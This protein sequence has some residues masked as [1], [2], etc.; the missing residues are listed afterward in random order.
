[1]VRISNKGVPFFSTAHHRTQPSCLALYKCLSFCVALRQQQKK[2]GTYCHDN[3]QLHDWRQAHANECYQRQSVINVLSIEIVQSHIT[4]PITAQMSQKR[5]KKNL[6]GPHRQHHTSSKVSVT[7]CRSS[8]TINC[9]ISMN[10]YVLL[11][12]FWT[13]FLVL[14]GLMHYGSPWWHIKERNISD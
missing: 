1:M 7:W 3:L 2:E 5:K 11:V 6:G 4:L 14:F 9:R 10:F 8:C 13:I 12:I